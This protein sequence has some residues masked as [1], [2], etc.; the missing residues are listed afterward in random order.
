MVRN[1]QSRR[2]ARAQCVAC[3]KFFA[4]DTDRQE[5]RAAGVVSKGAAVVA[6]RRQQQA[7]RGR[8][9]RHT[10]QREV[11]GAATEVL[12]DHHDLGCGSKAKE[13]HCPR[14]QSRR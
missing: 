9:G 6:A 5:K 12:A 1:E 14:A 8:R 11:C 3:L 2:R 4:G 7:A 13:S 10:A